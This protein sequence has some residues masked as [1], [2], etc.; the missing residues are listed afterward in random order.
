[1]ERDEFKI[2]VK[3]MKAV[4]A[5][6][7]FIPDQDAFNVWYA[8]LKD[9]TYEQANLAVQKYM[10]TEKFPP[11]IADIRQKANEIVQPDVESLT[12]LQA[13]SLVRKAMSNSGYHADE[14]FAKLPE[15]CRIAVGSPANLREWALMDKD[16]VETVEQSHFI[17]NYRVAQKRMKEDAMIP[18]HIKTLI[19]KMKDDSAALAKKDEPIAEIK[20]EIEPKLEH[21]P[22][23]ENIRERIEA[24]FREQEAKQF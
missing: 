20:V 16:E 23:P 12:E 15:A 11:A 14:E 3:A 2:L 4:Y 6:P 21:C 5:Q 9:L 8:L 22:P 18:M 13:W 7:T 1:M 24:L 10:I 17:R 19:G